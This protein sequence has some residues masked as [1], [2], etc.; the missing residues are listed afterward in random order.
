MRKIVTVL[1]PA[2]N[3]VIGLNLSPAR[4][5]TQT[6][7]PFPAGVSIGADYASKPPPQNGLI[8]EG[9]VGIG[10]TSTGSQKLDVSGNVSVSGNMSV[11]GN[12]YMSPL[13]QIGGI[14]DYHN[15]GLR[16]SDSSTTDLWQIGPT[17]SST[18]VLS[19]YVGTTWTDFFALSSTGNIGIKTDAP[20]TSLDMSQTTDALALPVGNSSNRPTGANLKNGEIR[21]NTQSNSVE[22][23]V[24]GAWTNLGAGNTGGGSVYCTSGACYQ[25]NYGGI[26]FINGGACP[27][28]C[29]GQESNVSTSCTVI[30]SSGKSCSGGGGAACPG[31]NLQN[32]LGGTGSC[33][34]GCP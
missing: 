18:L 25:D 11:V 13:L 26:V 30:T 3:L 23:Y 31:A 4:A 14:S 16:L 29:S 7:Y 15:G 5:Q 32:V 34:S 2:V 28:N 10:T 22:A 8:V 17:T 1:I 6:G 20:A 27:S 12:S 19:H 33:C 21:Y 9:S 24:N